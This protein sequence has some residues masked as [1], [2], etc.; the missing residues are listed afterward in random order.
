MSFAVNYDDENI[1]DSFEEESIVIQNST[2]TPMKINTSLQQ[3][4]N[5]YFLRMSIEIYSFNYPDYNIKELSV[6]ISQNDENVDKSPNLM[7]FDVI[8]PKGWVSSRT[9]TND[10]SSKLKWFK[11]FSFPNKFNIKKGKSKIDLN[12]TIEFKKSKKTENNS[13]PLL[14]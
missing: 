12:W 2:Q 7:R 11:E 5:D 6:L 4:G 13:F 3:K 9:F 8:S 14:S 10:Y 1:L